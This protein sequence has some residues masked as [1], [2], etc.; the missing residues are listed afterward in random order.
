MSS[1]DNSTIRKFAPRRFDHFVCIPSNGASGGLV[2]I[3]NSAVF[4][5]TIV[6]QESFAV[7]INFV[8]TMSNDSWNLVNV[9]G[10]CTEPRRSEFVNWLYNLDIQDNEDW[11]L[12]GDFNFYRYSDSRNRQG[13]NLSD[14][15]IFNDIINHL[16]LIELPIKVR[17]YTWSNMQ[18][19]PLLV[20]LDW[21]FTSLNW[22]IKFPNTVVNP[23]ARPVSDHIP[24]VVSINTKIPKSSIFR[25]ENYWLRQPGFMELV[26]NVWA[27]HVHG[28]SAKRI[29]GKLKL[30]RQ[31]L[32]KW[33]GSLSGIDS[34]IENCNKL[35]LML[36]D[37][38]DVRPLHITSGILETS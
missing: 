38:A 8:S 3:W 35:I 23:L 28:N 32:R 13:A 1:F 15:N 25:F 12:M 14:I 34:Q 26:D 11:L 16:G 37:Y 24:C 22:T 21:F 18:Q 30:L 20:Q 17:S 19:N 4:S 9:Y 5:G 36:D 10:P 6:A 31:G 2:I 33:S 27:I 7:V 29:V